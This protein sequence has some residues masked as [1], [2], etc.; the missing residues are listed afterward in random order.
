MT[1]ERRAGGHAS[2]RDT[3]RLPEPVA[4]HESRDSLQWVVQQ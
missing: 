4:R 2:E 1:Y 3:V